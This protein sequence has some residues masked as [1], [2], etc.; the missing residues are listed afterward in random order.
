MKNTFWIIAGCLNISTAFLHLVGGQLDLIDPLFQ[1]NLQQQV[2]TE[3]LGVWH[4]VTVILFVSSY[5]Y[6]K[7]G[8]TKKDKQSDVISLLNILYISFALVFV[9]VSL[10][11]SILAPQWILLFPIGLLGFIGEKK[12]KV[13][14]DNQK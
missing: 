7:N 10:Y 11:Q 13:K 1:S 2:Q 9:G 6:L 12:N 3:L 4:M 5:I 8:W 14:I